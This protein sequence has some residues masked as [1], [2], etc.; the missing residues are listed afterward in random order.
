MTRNTVTIAAMLGLSLA[1]CGG[2]DGAAATS[3]ASPTQ[4]QANDAAN[5]TCTAY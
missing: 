5:F 2:S 4:A 1:A 3:A